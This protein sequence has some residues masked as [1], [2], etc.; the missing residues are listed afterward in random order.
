MLKIIVNLIIFLLLIGAVIFGV[1]YLTTVNEWPLWVGALILAGIIGGV[2]TIVLLRRYLLR[3]NERKFVK[4][5]I[6]QEDSAIFTTVQDNQLLI[7]DLEKQWEKSI[8]TLYGSKLSKGH[9]PIYALPWI[10]IVGE[11]GAGKTSLIKNSRL[12][13]A[14]TDIEETAQYAGTKNCDWWFFEDAIILDTAG[15]YTVPIDSKKDNAE[16][17]RFLALLSKYRKKEPLNGM[18]VAISADRLLENNKDLIQAEALNIRKRIDQLMISIGAKFPV[19]LM[20]TKMDKVYGFTDFCDT[21]PMELQSQAMGY[22]NESLNNHWQEVLDKGIDFIKSKI[23]SL[24]LF[25]I[26]KDTK[27]IKNL[28]LFSKEFDR[29]V[30]ALKDFSHIIF[31]DNPYQK[32]P[33]LRG[34]YFSSALSDVF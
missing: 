28:L 34:V 9:N 6:A 24:E 2:L 10:L 27:E 16:W 18:I 21:L 31:G 15:R 5:V 11:S 7:N 26:Q 22:M 4:R 8:K 3:N 1:W 32:I 25:I 30:P 13:S 17:E 14:I 20:V 19:Y 12:S 33:M 23:R 29:L